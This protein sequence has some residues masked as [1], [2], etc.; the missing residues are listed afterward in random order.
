MRC[1][2]LSLGVIARMIRIGMLGR[3]RACD[4]EYRI[5]QDHTITQRLETKAIQSLGLQKPKYACKP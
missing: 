1:S 2:R 3:W 5:V 4:P